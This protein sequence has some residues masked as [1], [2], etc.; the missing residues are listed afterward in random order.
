MLSNEEATRKFDMA[1]ECY[2]KGDYVSAEKLFIEVAGCRESDKAEQAVLNLLSAIYSFPDSGLR[3]VDN[4]RLWLIVLA[5]DFNNGWAKAMLGSVYCGVDLGSFQIKADELGLGKDYATGL[6]LIEEG[7]RSASK[8][9]SKLEFVSS[10]YYIIATA[11]DECARKLFG[12]GTKYAIYICLRQRAV[13]L[14]EKAYAIKPYE[15]TSKL[16]EA[17]KRKLETDTAYGKY[18]CFASEL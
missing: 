3:S 6:T 12:D 13:E 9:D 17:L 14:N 8:E 16:I 5:T 7:L 18:S 10:D 4:F 11:Y 1:Y 2:E 15:E